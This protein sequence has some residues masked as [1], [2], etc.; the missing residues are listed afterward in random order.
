MIDRLSRASL[1]AGD[2]ILIAALV[3]LVLSLL[4]AVFS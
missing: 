3:A 4:L 2:T 1:Y